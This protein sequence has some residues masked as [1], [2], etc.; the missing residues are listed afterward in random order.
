MAQDLR[1]VS[2]DEALSLFATNNLDLRVSRLETMELGGL[3][4]QSEAFPNPTL[5]FSHEPLSGGTADYSESYVNLTQR[6]QLPGQRSARMN[7]ADWALRSA[8]SRSRADSARLAFDVKRTYVEAVLAEELL[9]V[10]ERVAAVFRRAA[11]NATTRAEAGDISQYE[12]RRILVERT[13][14]ENLLADAEIRASSARRSLALLILPESEVVEVAPTGLAADVPPEPGMDLTT[15]DAT[16][17]RYEIAAAEAAIEAASADVRL[18]RAERVPDV[19]A[20]AGFKRQSDGLRGAFLGVSIPVPLFDRRSGAIEGA[21]ARVGALET[22]LSLTR[23]QI[24]NDLRRAMETYQS[25]RRRSALLG[26]EE[27]NA[28]SDLLEIAQVAYDLGD[29]D[30]LELLDA[31]SALR[32][33]RSAD[34]QVKADLWT[35][36]YNLERAVGGFDIE[37]EPSTPVPESR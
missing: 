4:R 1:R 15:L 32:G 17:R 2:V 35:A 11:E 7:G 14:Y 20:T 19:A 6:L 8:E 23:R 5:S 10:T 28:S 37:A 22:R 24:D 31:A 34:A 33:A 36:Y 16:S 13:R 26:G 12:L 29:M 25:L 3:A 21:E 30:L 27:L 18:R 9:A